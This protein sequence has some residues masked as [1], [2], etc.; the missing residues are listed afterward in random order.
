MLFS[1]KTGGFLHICI[2]SVEEQHEVSRIKEEAEKIGYTVSSCKP[3]EFDFDSIKPTHLLVRAIKGEVKEARKAAALALEK[4]V[5][6]VDEKVAH[7]L[8]RNKYDNFQLFIEHGLYMPRTEMLL[9]EN[10]ERIN[11][12]P[13]DYIVIKDT[14]GKRGEGVFR[15]KKKELDAFI[16]TLPKE[17]HFLAQE[18]VEIEK[19]FR[20]FVIGTQAIGAFSKHTEGWLHNVAKGAEPIPEKLTSELAETAVKAAGAVSTEIA[21]VDIGEVKTAAG[22]P[23][24]KKELFVLEVNR[25]PQF[26]GF[27]RATGLNVARSIV[28]YI[29]SK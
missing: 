27:E 1:V 18:Y 22:K 4:G 17:R 21:G 19:E 28:M 11:E 2:I 23:A 14:S 9:P 6:V 13:S 15:A 3:S 7:G 5:K 20:V 25:A 12:F 24:K 10:T 8:T 16:K 26:K 29:S